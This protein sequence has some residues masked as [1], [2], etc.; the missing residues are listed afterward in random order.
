[1][2]DLF[3]VVCGVEIHSVRIEIYAM[4]DIHGIKKQI[5]D[6]N[7]TIPVGI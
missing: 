1:V 7:N 4:S 2:R 6:D 3:K 5:C